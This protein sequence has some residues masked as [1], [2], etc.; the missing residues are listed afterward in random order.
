MA[1]K[2][3]YVDDLD[4][5]T[6][7]GVESV[8]FTYKG[9][10]YEIDLSEDHRKDLDEALSAY[11]DKARKVTRTQRSVARST[12]SDLVRA[13]MTFKYSPETMAEATEW[14]KSDEGSKYLKDH[15]ID[16]KGTGRIPYRVVE[17]YL[18]KDA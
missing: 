15:K 7:E 1:E 18:N 5:T 16:Y 10:D 2:V 13:P 3:F 4:G 9:Q 11:T 14:A 8:T 6:T 17:A 12:E